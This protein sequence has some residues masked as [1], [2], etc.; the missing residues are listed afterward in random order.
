MPSHSG[1]AA[2][3]I[4]RHE[5]WGAI[6]LSRPE[7]RNA[8]TGPMVTTM[9]EGL[10]ELLA[11]GARVVVLRGEGGAFCSGLDLQAFSTRPEPPW[12]ESWAED[13][14]GLHRDLYD[15][16]ATII[17]ALERYA[18]NAGSSLAL[19]CDLI[20]AGDSSYLLV[21]EASVGMNAPMNVA[22]LRLRTSEATA[23][24][25]ALAAARVSAADL[26][27]LGLAYQVA[28]DT[29]VI[30][31]AEALAA[32][33]AGYQGAGLA[34][35]KAAMRRPLAPGVDVFDTVREGG[36]RSAAPSRVAT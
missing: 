13:W 5:G 27:R 4:E 23:A 12:L 34:A 24:Q 15:C 33:L 7:R 32:R 3:R 30:A 14:A 31:E 9:R 26:F 17:G 35:I 36:F 21:G 11:H 20:V 10:A 19:A 16:P 28:P 2:A 25:L 18:I 29:Q 1:E 8:L 6:I 22:W